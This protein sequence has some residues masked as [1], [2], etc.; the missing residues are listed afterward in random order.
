MKP[1]GPV[2]R[3]SDYIVETI[4][5][6]MATDL[7]SA[8]HYARRGARSAMYRH[9][10]FHRDNPLDCLGAAI[11]MPASPRTVEDWKGALTLSRLVVEPGMPTNSASFLLGGSINLIRRDHKYRVLVTYAD[12][13]EGHT[14]AIY[15]ATNWTYLGGD[16]GLGNVTFVDADGKSYSHRAITN[17]TVPVERR[18]ALTRVPSTPKHKFVLHLDRTARRPTEEQNS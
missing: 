18:E 7:V 14:G 12:T 13:A 1:A 5:A 17:K 4:P 10:L 11:W 15:R 9:G 16:F 8:Y 2:L 6:G 3:R